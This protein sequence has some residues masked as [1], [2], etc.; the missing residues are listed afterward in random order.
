MKKQI[1]KLAAWFCTA[2]ILSAMVFTV[3]A[4]YEGPSPAFKLDIESFD[5]LS[6]EPDK[7]LSDASGNGALITANT[8]QSG[9]FILPNGTATK[10]LEFK[11]NNPAAKNV[12][13]NAP[14]IPLNPR[15]FSAEM[16]ANVNFE[17]SVNAGKLMQ[18]ASADMNT[19]YTFVQTFSHNSNPNYKTSLNMAANT[20]SQTGYESVA[21]YMDKWT[22]FVFVW[23]WN[24]DETEVT[25]EMY[26]DG[27]LLKTEKKGNQTRVL[28]QDKVITLGSVSKSWEHPAN[29]KVGSFNLYNQALTLA[30]AQALYADSV[31]KYVYT[32]QTAPKFEMDLSGYNPDSTTGAKGIRD[33]SGNGAAITANTALGGGF[34]AI[35]GNDTKYVT[36]KEGAADNVRIDTAA[37]GPNPRLMSVAMWAKVDN[38][39]SPN[40]GKLFALSKSSGTESANTNLQILKNDAG[41]RL[42]VNAGSASTYETGTAYFNKWT[43]YVVTNEWNAENTAVTI[44]LYANGEEIKSQSFTGRTRITDDNKFLYYIGAWASENTAAMDVSTFRLYDRILSPEEIRAAYAAEA[45]NHVPAENKPEFSPI[46][47]DVTSV[48]EGRMKA[49][50][51]V[52]NF[53][54]DALPVTV[55][56]G[57]YKDARLAGIVSEDCLVPNG[58]NAMQVSTEIELVLAEG[59]TADEYSLK[60]FVWDGLETMRPYLPCKTLSA[61]KP[62]YTAAFLGGSITEGAGAEQQDLCYVSRMEDYFTRVYG[63]DYTVKVVNAGKGGT[64]SSLGSYRLGLEVIPCEPDV[65]FVEFAQN[66]AYGGMYAYRETERNMESIVRQLMQMKKV[67]QIVFLYTTNTSLGKGAAEAHTRI[68]DYYGIPHVDLRQALSDEISR[69]GGAAEDY[70]APND[71]VH[72]NGTGHGVYAAAIQKAIETQGILEQTHTWQDTAYTN[73]YVSAP[74]LV[75]FED[76]E[77]TGAWTEIDSDNKWIPKGWYSET[78]GD[79]ISYT[80]DGACIGI[81]GFKTKDSGKADYTVTDENGNTVEQ[82][83]LDLFGGG[84]TYCD[85]YVSNLAGGPHTITLR[86]KGEKNANSAG[87]K[88]QF[89]YFMVDPGAKYLSG[90]DAMKDAFSP[91]AAVSL[92]DGD[93]TLGKYPNT[94]PSYIN[95]LINNRWARWN[96]LDFGQGGAVDMT[97][98]V[99]S[100]NAETKSTIMDIYLDSLSSA[101]IGTLTVYGTEGW[102]TYVSNGTAEFTADISQVTGI[103][104]IY[105]VPQAGQNMPYNLHSFQFIK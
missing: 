11:Q 62:V 29:M 103:H 96:K 7:G 54:G 1:K 76:C 25:I 8:Q 87:T 16:W 33:I 79:T 41:D 60:A 50:T 85:M 55:A 65:V 78:P 49:S 66:D 6:Q 53:T 37:M 52:R 58:T 82:G 80:F 59:E 30:D 15:E 68:A 43:H 3:S 89:G 23:R 88:V 63:N 70:F 95:T 5:G 48:R 40:Y 19:V 104:D 39:A 21:G 4:A 10:Y 73:F 77:A 99:A 36:L 17:G 64:P 102:N 74:A 61:E 105:L 91:V 28:A 31:D 94:T 44:R 47:F 14:A 75:S 27:K 100:A 57:L 97:A 38:T 69:T 35:N 101:P 42:H 45:E 24:E 90:N 83:T 2:A 86:V 20:P 22:H 26:A 84:N 56:V 12:V 13:I 92:F 32:D 72:P 67:P 18:T 98:T 51:T 81:Y 93:R 71:S 9:Q 46:A 34:K